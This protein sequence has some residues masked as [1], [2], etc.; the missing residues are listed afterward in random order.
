MADTPHSAPVSFSEFDAVSTAAWQE[1]IKRD[2]KGADPAA[3]EWATAE[4]LNV[5]PFYHQEALHGLP[6]QAL[7]TSTAWL[8]IPTYA[9]GAADKGHT[10]IARAADALERGADGIYFELTDAASFDISY[11]HERLPLSTSYIGYSVRI[12]AASFVE[13]LLATGTPT[14]RGFLRFDPVTDHAPDLPHQL[15]ELR[16]VLT[17]TRHMAEFRAL[18]LNGAFF[19]NRG[20]T[21]I[22]QVGFALAAAAVYLE[23]LP[24]DDIPLAEV[25]AAFQIQVGLNP[26]YFFEI[27][28]LRALRRLWATLLHAFGLPA[29]AAQALRIFAVTST[30]SQTTLDPHTNLLRATTATMAAVLGGANAVGVAPFDSL[31]QSPNEFSGR[32]A[33]NL[34]VILREEAGLNR[35][36]DPAAGSYYLET[37]TDQ[38]AREAWAVFQRVDAAGGLS[39][40]I[41]MVLQ[42]LHA[43]AQMQFQRIAS[44]EQVIIGTNRFQNPHEQFDYNPKKLLRSKEFDS[45]RAAYPSEVLRLATVL[46][47]QRREKKHRR[48]AVVLLGAHTN[49]LI[50]ESFLRLLPVQER[51][52]LKASH[53]AGTLSVLFSTPEAATLMYATPDQFGHFAR[54]VCRVAINEPD[55]VPPTLLTAD[56]ATMQEAVSLFGF[57]EFTVEGY[58][59]DDVLARL[60]GR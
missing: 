6:T 42:E 29:D 15:A 59:T 51:L 26:N 39:V 45:T 55:F 16:T 13:R 12:G 27:A 20:G 52:A 14:L 21:V 19:A 60:Q 48:A 24:T 3:L 49:Q 43:V 34:P 36:A 25:A 40:A 58:S 50:M 53:P 41:G 11:L 1:R 54:V 23:Q 30:W 5:Q 8:N 56:L 17:L 33:R 4:G 9:V 31:Y 18:T 7:T 38:M 37:I 57:R 28:K 22:Q 35:V 10:A 2:L 47:F 32:L 46:H 44:G